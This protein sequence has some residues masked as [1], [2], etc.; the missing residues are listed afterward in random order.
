MV[1]IRLF[2]P[3]D[4]NFAAELIRQEKWGHTTK[5]VRRCWNFEPEGCFIAEQDGERVGH[6]FSVNYST[7]GWIGLLI[8]QQSCRGQGIGTT[9]M[10][11][12]MNYLRNLG[13]EAIRL[14]AVPEAVTLYQ[15]LGFKS[16][17]DSLRFY[18]ELK[19]GR[20]CLQAKDEEIHQI[21]DDELEILGKFDAKCFGANRLKVLQGLYRDFP[22]HCLVARNDGIMGYIMCRETDSGF[23]LGPWVCEEEHP[24]VARDLIVSFLHALKANSGLCVGIPAPNTMGIQLLEKLDFSLMSRSIRMFWGKPAYSGNAK[25][26]FGIGGPEKG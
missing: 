11:T 19:P 9:L 8:I 23:W 4:V 22:Q 18:R 17:F 1:T 15:R 6:V 21:K 14:E 2:E 3:K 10:R 26:N 24:E 16:E 13:V 12:A 25:E 7:V 5:D 20:T